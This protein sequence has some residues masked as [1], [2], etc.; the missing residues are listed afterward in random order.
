MIPVFTREFLGILRAP[1]SIWALLAAALAFSSLVLARWPAGDLVDLSG[2]GSR[3]AFLV[4]ASALLGGVLLLVPAFPATSIVRERN[5]G[6]LLLLLNSPLTGRAIYSGKFLGVLAFA[7]LMLCTTLPAAAAV[8]AMGGVDPL[9]QIGLLYAVLAVVA[10]LATTIGLLVSTRAASPDAAVRITYGLVFAVAFLTLAPHALTKGTNGIYALISQWLRRLSP[11]P[12]VMHLVGQGGSVG[13]GILEKDSGVWQFLVAGLGLSA[14]LA[15]ATMLQ[16]NH[17][18]FDRSRDQG[19]ITDD[20][21]TLV[22]WFRRLVYLVDPQRRKSGIP[23]FLNPVMV[24]EFR[25]RRFGRFHW[26]LRLAAVCAVVSL[27]M[28]LAA[29]NGTMDWGVETIGGLLVILQI[30]L[31]VLLTPSLSAGLISSEREGGGWNLLRSTTLSGWRIASGKLTSVA[32]TMLL[33]LAATLPGYLVMTWIKPTMWNQVV[34]ALISVL[35]AVAMTL[36]VSA[37]VGAF[38]SRTASATVTVYVVLMLMY[39]GP[40]V[41]WAFRDDPFGRPLVERAL[42]ITPLGAAL[43]V[44]GMPG[45]AQYQ[46]LPAAWWVAGITCIVALVV[47]AIQVWRLLKPE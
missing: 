37:A 34:L 14:V 45:F 19:K 46:L 10:I 42:L 17:L 31:V 16:L 12:V 3:G 36:A 11:L 38:H 29:T 32:W 4:F 26:L 18:L 28:T 22:R 6:T 33:V 21:S 35:L 44:I 2:S 30:A 7:G 23:V 40:L 8:Y 47:F 15:V 43:S 1:R 9:R 25:T 39:L 20:Q 24:K 5:K 27:L 41:V 13:G